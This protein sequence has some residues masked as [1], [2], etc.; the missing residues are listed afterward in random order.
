MPG[1]PAE[2]GLSLPAKEL[3]D[4]ASDII[5]H[6]TFKG[7]L[8]AIIVRRTFQPDKTTFVTPDG[9]SQQLGFVV[10]P[11]GGEILPHV[12]TVPSSFNANEC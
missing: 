12:H 2:R 4:M 3:A 9:L 11:A 10:Y 7:E 1:H 5:E 8:L 6:I